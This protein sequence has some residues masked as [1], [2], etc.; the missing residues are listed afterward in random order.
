MT[1]LGTVL[2]LGLLAGL[3]NLQVGA[4]LGLVR[5]ERARRLTLAG[6]FLLCETAMPLAGFA[7]GSLVQR[8]AGPLA[9]GIGTL[10]LAL[11][12]GLITFAALREQKEEE[13]RS[14][15]LG[16]GW[17]LLI[18]LPVSLSFDNLFVGLGLGSLG[19]PVVVSSLL[20]GGVSGGL[21]C[22]GLFTG[23]RV[24]RFLPEWAELLS[25]A[26]LVAL[27]AF[28]FWKDLA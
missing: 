24:R 26:Y 10:V 1:G 16:S 19:Y 4:G 18:V 3:D 28:R 21:G 5:M 27:A 2:F 8:L 13:K 17:L 15:R 23:A 7:L 22:V 9:E 14:E 25:G 6:S 20:I 12:G 11:C